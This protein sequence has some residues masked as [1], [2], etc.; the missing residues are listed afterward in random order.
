MLL[1]SFSC[2]VSAQ[3][4][5]SNQTGDQPLSQVANLHPTGSHY[6]AR[7]AWALNGTEAG[8]LKPQAAWSEDPAGWF[9]KRKCHCQKSGY[10]FTGPAAAANLKPLDPPLPYK[11]V[12]VAEL[13][14][15]LGADTPSLS[16]A[17]PLLCTSGDSRPPQTLSGTSLGGGDQSGTWE[18]VGLNW[19]HTCQKGGPPVT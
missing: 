12:V 3:E 10:G 15:T 14:K 16:S 5:Q 1:F 18:E 11:T 9:C 6:V 7:M 4:M 17:L 2:S 13:G 8:G 19:W